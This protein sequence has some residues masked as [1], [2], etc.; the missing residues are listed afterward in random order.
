M[1]SSGLHE[2]LFERESLLA[3]VANGPPGVHVHA[4]FHLLLRA[5]RGSFQ[6]SGKVRSQVLKF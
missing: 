1:W 3:R 6:E 4:C 2:H 5:L